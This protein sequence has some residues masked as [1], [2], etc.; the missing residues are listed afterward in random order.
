MADLKYV[1]YC[2][3][4]CRLCSNLARIPQQ[5]AALRETLQKEGWE[6]WGQHALR[7]FA[8][9]WD[10]LERLSQSDNTCKG[11]REGC[12]DP[13]CG[14]RKCARKKRVEVCSSCT[15]YPCHQIE[16]LAKRYPNLI[17]DGTRQRQIGIETWVEEQELRCRTGF[18]YA[19]IRYPPGPNV[20]PGGA[21]NRSQPIRSETNRTSSAAGSRR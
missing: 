2:G 14:I 7:G 10:A 17:A 15:Q 13:E 12:G 16:A 3:L 1:T 19:D 20:E 6:Y 8:E 4:Y 11:C 9:F 18:C 5:A 21:A